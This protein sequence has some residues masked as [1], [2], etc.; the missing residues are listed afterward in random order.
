MNKPIYKAEKLKAIVNERG[1]VT[2]ML[3]LSIATNKL[4]TEI[5]KLFKTNRK[6][7]KV[8]MGD[9]VYALAELL[10]KVDTTRRYF[11]IKR[12]EVQKIYDK[13]LEIEFMEVTKGEE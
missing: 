2:E 3:D 8:D 6:L 9:Y 7:S 4:N 13:L 12:E 11:D 10:L 5:N 1:I